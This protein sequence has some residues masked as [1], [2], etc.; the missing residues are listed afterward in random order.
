MEL[1]AILAISNN[2]CIGRQGQIPWSLKG[3]MAH[4]RTTTLDGHLLM[5]RRTYES[6]GRCLPRRT[7]YVLTSDKSYVP[8][9]GGVVVH[10]ADDAIKRATETAAKRLFV[11]GGAA[12]YE[13]LFPKTD[14]I[15]AT[16]V[17]IVVDDG[18]T[19]VKLPTEN[20]E[21]KEPS[22]TVVCEEAGIRYRIVTLVQNKKRN[23]ID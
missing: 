9:F 5:G 12:V 10:N 3:D 16:F 23:Q 8:K 15:I 4:F 20:W 11:C 7:I 18:D 21:E 19:F 17:D 22:A 14:I 2:G 1:V 13:S 6:I